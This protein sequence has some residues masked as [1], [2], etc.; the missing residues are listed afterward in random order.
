MRYLT[1]LFIFFG[2]KLNAQ[3]I[4][5]LDALTELPI[6]GVS[7]SSKTKDLGVISNN[8][9]ITNLSVFS[10]KETLIIQHIAYQKIEQIKSSIQQKTIFLVLKTH[11]LENVEITESKESLKS[12][13]IVLIQN[14]ALIIPTLG[15]DS[16]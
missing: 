3:E 9:G 6:E 10:S 1:I 16:P 8:M 15:V 4:I 12:T 14:I 2:L 7:V 5:L 13:L 11:S